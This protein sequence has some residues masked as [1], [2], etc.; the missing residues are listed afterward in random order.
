MIFFMLQEIDFCSYNLIKIGGSLVRRAPSLKKLLHEIAVLTEAGHKFL[1]VAGG[2]AGVDY[3]RQLQ[4]KYDLN[5]S[6]VHWMAISAMD[7][8][9]ALMQSLLPSACPISIS[10]RFAAIRHNIYMIRGLDEITLH[11]L[12]E[13]WEVPSDSIAYYLAQKLK[14]QKC[15]L[16]KDVDG[17]Y[18]Q[19]HDK[20][21]LSRRVGADEIAKYAGGCIDKFIPVLMRKWLQPLYI[22]NGNYPE[23]LRQLI[24]GEEFVGTIIGNER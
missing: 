22:I 8:N 21:S 15:I 4:E 1:I 18:E 14:A 19:V 24:S 9:T 23:R 3:V 13:S 12:P 20:N 11:E 5:D 2:G 7:I 6:V 10:R 17:I 16:L